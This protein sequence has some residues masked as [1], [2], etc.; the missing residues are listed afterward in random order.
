MKAHH[1]WI[2]WI[3]VLLDESNVS[4]LAGDAIRLL[5]MMSVAKKGGRPSCR[6]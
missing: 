6:Q 5:I 3:I 2:I 1:H 4:R